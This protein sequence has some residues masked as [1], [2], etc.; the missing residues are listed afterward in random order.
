MKYCPLPDEIEPGVKRVVWKYW[1]NIFESF[2][3]ETCGSSVEPVKVLLYLRPCLDW[4]KID[5]RFGVTVVSI[6]GRYVRKVVKSCCSR[7]FNL[8][9]EKITLENGRWVRD[10][11]KELL[12]S[13]KLPRSFT[14]LGLPPA[15]YKG[16]W[17]VTVEPPDGHQML[18]V[19][20]DE[21]RAKKQS[22]KG[23]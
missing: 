19:A 1:T 13:I 15:C 7:Y 6:Y 18:L 2:G 4:S 9:F 8:G 12:S 11:R 14:I 20:F 10:F 22:G 5:F 23:K 16:R 21:A 3:C 17:S